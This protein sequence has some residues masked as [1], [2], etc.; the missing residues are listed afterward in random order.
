RNIMHVKYILTIIS[1]IILL[2]A[3]IYSQDAKKMKYNKLTPEEFA[4]IRCHTYYS[5]YVIQGFAFVG[6]YP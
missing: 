3:I 2:V 4:L 6:C 5:Y 1:G